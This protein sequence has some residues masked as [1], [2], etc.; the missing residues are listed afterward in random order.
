IIASDDEGDLVAEDP[1]KQGRSMI[2][3]LDLDAGPE[4]FG[5]GPEVT[6]VDAELN[7]TSTFVSTV[8]TQRH[9]NT[10]TPLQR[11][12]WRSERVLLKLRARLKWIK[13]SLQGR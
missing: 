8:S 9:A 1:S 11:H 6:T 10:T 2:E 5:A 12:L 4:G 3:E 13:L 7:T